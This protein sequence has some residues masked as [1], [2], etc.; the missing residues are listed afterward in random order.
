MQP[1]R[2]IPA[3]IIA[4]AFTLTGCAEGEDQQNASTNTSTA[5]SG[6]DHDH[7][8]DD[9]HDHGHGHGHHG[10][11][12]PLGTVT[13]GGYSVRAGRDE[14]TITPGGDSPIDVWVEDGD[15]TRI[16]AVRFW[17]GLES[18]AGSVRARAEVEFADKPNQWHTHAEIPE[19]MP[20]GSRLWVEL[21]IE[22]QGR[23]TGSFDLHME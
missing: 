17:I 14:G 4:L 6:T 22:G 7:D 10:E 16:N 3:T 5:T 19:P 12:I 9:D 20:A 15:L 23:M 21:D 1:L 18:G 11:S 8:H 2:L 13:I